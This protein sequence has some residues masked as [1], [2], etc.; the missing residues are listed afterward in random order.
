MRIH[1]DSICL[2]GST[3][4]QWF[5]HRHLNVVWLRSSFI[6]SC[7]VGHN[8]SQ[9]CI[10]S[11]CSGHH[12]ITNFQDIREL[13]KR[14]E[15]ER[16]L[17]SVN[18]AARTLLK[19]WNNLR[20]YTEP[21]ASVEKETPLK[22]TNVLASDLEQLYAAEKEE[23]LGIS[24]WGNSTPTAG[25][26]ETELNAKMQSVTTAMQGVEGT[27]ICAEYFRMKNPVLKDLKTVSVGG[28]EPFGISEEIHD[29]EMVDADALEEINDISSEEEE[30]E[31]QMSDE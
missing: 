3:I 15:K 8:R 19:M 14:V 22:C 1:A 11:K 31:S 5:T 27:A 29:Q 7:K 21:D 6:Y 20:Y 10:G 24:Q 12:R 2:K 23:F 30:D 9:R 4:H 26:V 17:C 25:I 13:L 16:N 18:D 28:P